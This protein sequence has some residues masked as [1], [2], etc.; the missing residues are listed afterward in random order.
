[1]T[2]YPQGRWTALFGITLLTFTAF[3]DVTI[4]NT[5]LPFIQQNLHASVIQ[6]QW[7][8]NIVVMILAMLMIT[9][10]K[11]G[12]VFG[13]SRVFFIGSAIFSLGAIGAALSPTIF[14]L[15][16]FRG[17]QGFG[18]ATMFT[19]SSAM[20]SQLFPEEEHAKAVSL[21][22][23]FTGF[24]L[25]IGP[26]LGGLLLTL[27]NN[28]WRWVFF[29][30]IPIIIIGFSLCLK[31][32]TNMHDIKQENVKIDIPGTFLLITG[33]GFLVF[34][35]I[36][37]G[38]FSWPVSAWV[39]ILIGL[40][41][42]FLLLI[43]ERRSANPVLDFQI[44]ES[45]L[46]RLSLLNALPA[47]LICFVI[48]FFDPLYLHTVRAQPA[49]M[50]GL[51]MLVAPI[52]QILISVFFSH[53]RKRFSLEHL[54]Y[55]SIFSACIATGG[56]VLLGM[57]SAYSLLFMSLV[58]AGITWGFANT[59]TIS[60]AMEGVSPEHT[61]T[62][63]GTIFTA[64]NLSGAILLAIYSVILNHVQHSQLA[65]KLTGLPAKNDLIQLAVTNSE[66]L[67]E[68]V[69][70]LVGEGQAMGVLESFRSSFFAGFHAST[71][72]GFALCLLCFIT[73]LS[74]RRH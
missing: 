15:I 65:Q 28:N 52:M 20:L 49:M 61:G 2:N 74:L 70:Q 13:R 46:I 1:M 66:S 64:W 45:K 68:K 59:A 47:G 56:H 5:A 55:F 67:H 63:I 3:L 69:A 25:A 34:G 24:G 73:A 43:V 12:D 41:A 40:V 11:M 57:G 8:T 72:V 37:G 19:V 17:L 23:G 29:I 36:H 48:M 26:L 32:L 62:T 10:G 16:F 4:V 27:S 31:Q 18:A 58:F 30:N 6:L 53:L 33:I 35:I 51:F 54:L 44:F 42:L 50:I 22:T 71:W 21:Y 9:V 38:Q 60:A 7:V 39:C 14:V